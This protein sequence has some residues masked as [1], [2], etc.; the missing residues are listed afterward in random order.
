M[1]Y[2]FAVP[3]TSVPLVF[4]EKKKKNPP[5]T[6][7]SFCIFSLLP[8]HIFYI[9]EMYKSSHGH[10]I[11][12][13]IYLLVLIAAM[14]TYIMFFSHLFWATLK[15]AVQYQPCALCFWEMCNRAGSI[16]QNRTLRT[17][18]SIECQVLQSPKISPQ[19]HR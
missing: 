4:R 2:S 6:F 3:L 13:H 10:D 9:S 5:L 11:I 17:H 7:T 15:A 8:S 1:F 12:L 16:V 18:D 19:V 14:L